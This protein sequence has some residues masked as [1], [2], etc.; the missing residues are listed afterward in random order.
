MPTPIESFIETPVKTRIKVGLAPVQ[1]AIHSLL[2]LTETERLSGLSSWVT[3]TVN[4]LTPEQRTKHYYVMIGFYFAIT[5]NKDWSSFPIYLDHLAAMDPVVLRDKI[6][7]SYAKL[8]VWDQAETPLDV[9]T[10]LTSE[11]NY[12]AFL[13]Q[14]FQ[15]SKLDE[16]LE[17]WAYQYVIDPP[18]MQEL[19]VSH[20][21]EF[22]EKYLRAEWER[23]RPTLQKAVDAFRQVDLNQM[24]N[25]EAAKYVLGQSLT[26]DFW[27]EKCERADRLYFAPSLHVGPYLGK[28]SMDGYFGIIFGAR[29]PESSSDYA[30]EL[31]LADIYVRLNAL[32]DENRLQILK[33]ISTQGEACSTEII[34]ACDL[35]QSAASR[36]LTQLT[37]IGFLSAR[38]IESAKCY[39]L[40]EERIGNAFE[41]IK[42]FL[43]V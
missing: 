27:K 24:E 21:K 29:L 42:N 39:R 32:A 20:L 16:E 3:D 19:V 10:A 8:P 36:H 26:E 25:Y 17:R 43:G 22:W 40:D 30:P 7:N 14:R 37:A 1:N 11:D 41:T 12:I 31:S 2:L 38:R 13:K 33:F 9:E 6:L 28:F 4:Q 35:S 34:D 23:V 15:E 5:S 18:A